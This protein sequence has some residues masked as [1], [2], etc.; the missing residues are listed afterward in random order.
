MGKITPDEARTVLRD[1]VV[2]SNAAVRQELDRYMFRAPAQATSYLDGYLRLLELR[3]AVEKQ[4]GAKF[5]AQPFHDFIVS[6]G[7]LPPKLL[8]EAVMEE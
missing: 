2:F 4:Q 7:L 3:C 1:D 8:R 5:Q 6:Q